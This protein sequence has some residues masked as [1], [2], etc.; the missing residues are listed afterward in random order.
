MARKFHGDGLDLLQ[1]VLGLVVNLGAG[2]SLHQGADHGGADLEV[3]QV[4][5]AYLV[6][7]EDVVER[8][9]QLEDSLALLGQL[10]ERAVLRV[11]VS[12][13]LGVALDAG[14]D[15]LPNLEILL[16]P[17]GDGHLLE[18]DGG[19]LHLHHAEDGGDPELPALGR[20]VEDGEIDGEEVVPVL[21]VL[22]VVL[23]QGVHG[24]LPG[25]GAG[26]VLAVLAPLQVADDQRHH[27][28]VAGGPEDVESH[29]LLSLGL[30][31]LE[32]LDE[33]RDVLLR[34][35]RVVAGAHLA[36][37]VLG[38]D[39]LGLGG[40]QASRAHQVGEDEVGG[41]LQVGL[42][43]DRVGLDQLE[44]LINQ[45][46]GGGLDV[47]SEGGHD[48]ELLG[49]A[50]LVLLNHLLEEHDGGGGPGVPDQLNVESA[51]GLLVLGVGLDGLV[52]LLQVLGGHHGHQAGQGL[53][54]GGELLLS[55]VIHLADI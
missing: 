4:A 10:V 18:L 7:G 40:V 3:R 13:Q 54:L 44:D 43:G 50:D 30:S 16:E 31:G 32:L 37:D 14:V 22:P 49:L 20:V 33:V 35:L 15:V 1:V 26:L 41:V 25:A 8:L 6:D 38:V 47:V 45:L 36:E 9:R 29:L 21:G 34:D 53:Q 27:R 24:G 52:H 23:Q 12:A 11:G 19:G 17:G 2:D 51:G 46:L 48:E 55:E 39:L 28:L 5:R 42:A